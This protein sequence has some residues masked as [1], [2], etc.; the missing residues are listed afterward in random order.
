MFVTDYLSDST[1]ASDI[2]QFFPVHVDVVT[3]AFV[4]G[5]AFSVVV[6]SER[7]PLCLDGAGKNGSTVAV[8]KTLE[9]RDLTYALD[10]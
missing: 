1:D 4:G 3:V 2:G 9:Q 8:S 5:V 7:L 10:V 6:V